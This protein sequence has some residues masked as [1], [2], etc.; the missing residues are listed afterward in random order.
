MQGLAHQ[1]FSSTVSTRQC[2]SLQR[3]SCKKSFVINVAGKLAREPDPLWAPP[4]PLT[5]VRSSYPRERSLAYYGGWCFFL[6]FQNIHSGCQLELQ[7][8][9][10]LL[11]LGFAWLPGAGGRLGVLWNLLF[12][13]IIVEHRDHLPPKWTPPRGL[14]GWL[15]Q[16]WGNTLNYQ[17]IWLFLNNYHQLCIVVLKLSCWKLLVILPVIYFKTF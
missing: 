16:G 3:T 4:R 1:S 13:I 9:R 10:A 11:F 14:Y 8:I 12:C 15:P 5:T 2:S 17:I 7:N 6:Q